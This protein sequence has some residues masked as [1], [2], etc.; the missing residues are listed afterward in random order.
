MRSA[1]TSSINKKLVSDRI[2]YETV[3]SSGFQYGGGS[4]RAFGDVT[5]DFEDRQYLTA[6]VSTYGGDT[7]FFEAFPPNITGSRIS[8]FNDDTVLFYSSALSASLN[9]AHSSSLK[10]SEHESVYDSHTALFR[11][12]YEGCKE[13]GSTVPF[14]N[15]TAVE[16][17]ETNPYVVTSTTKGDSYVDTDL[18]GE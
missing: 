14:G 12:A 9:N 1:V 8:R 6:S 18:S 16:I 4:L 2:D 13:D 10:R 5:A 11:L 7:I 3:S 15:K 17:T